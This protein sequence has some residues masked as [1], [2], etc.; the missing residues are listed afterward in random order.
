MSSHGRSAHQVP[1]K[2]HRTE[3]HFEAV[4]MNAKKIIV[5]EGAPLQNMLNYHGSNW[6]G[7]ISLSDSS[8]LLSSLPC[9]SVELVYTFKT[10]IAPMEI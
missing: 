9:S 1:F 7:K 5:N 4:L 8:F 10:P 3:Y 6:L 2:K